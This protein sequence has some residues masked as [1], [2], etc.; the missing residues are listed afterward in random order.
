MNVKEQGERCSC[1]GEIDCLYI[2]EPDIWQGRCFICGEKY[3]IIKP[4]ESG[5]MKK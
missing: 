5:I 4:D 2:I 1:S 3:I